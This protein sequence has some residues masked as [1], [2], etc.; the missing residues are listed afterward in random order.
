MKCIYCGSEDLSKSDIIPDALTNGKI[1]NP[2]VCRIEH[3]NK[4]RDAF[5]SKVISELA[6]ITNKL[7]IKS[8]K[9]NGKYALYKTNI[10][11]DGVSYK[12]KIASNA[13]LFSEH[14]TLKSEDGK[15]L[16]GPIDEIRKI[17]RIKTSDIKWVDINQMDIRQN[18]EIDFSIFF[19][20]EIYRLASKIAFEWYCLRNEIE[21]KYDFFDDII[22]YITTGESSKNIV[23]MVATEEVYMHIDNNMAG[24]GSHVLLS[25]VAPD[26]YVH[27]LVDLFGIVIYDVLVCE[28]NEKCKNNALFQS[29]S[30]DAKQNLF[31]YVDINAVMCDGILNSQENK[32]K[33]IAY[34]DLYKYIDNGLILTQKKEVMLPILLKKVENVFQELELT[35]RGLRRFVKEH[36]AYIDSEKG[37]NSRGTNSKDIFLFYVIFIVR[38]NNGLDSFADLKKYL[39]REIGNEDALIT[40]E[41]TEKLLKEIMSDENYTSYL[42]AGADKIEGWKL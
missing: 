7:D 20:K 34:W 28:V 8:S 27:V 41:R 17:K 38:K 4:F 18:I 14:K 2:C 36:R 24:F 12:A 39:D 35:I 26:N 33:E 21:D 5:E 9:G 16:L 13:E 25:Y 31:S 19:S 42:I 40:D 10:E 1:I 32:S 37:L 23:N 3:N 15:H 6:I 22:G 11:I 30:L 29:V